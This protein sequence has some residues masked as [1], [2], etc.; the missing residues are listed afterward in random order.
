MY[1]YVHVIPQHYGHSIVLD[2]EDMYMYIY[3]TF[4]LRCALNCPQV[5][6]YSTPVHPTGHPSQ[7]YCHARNN[8]KIRQQ[9]D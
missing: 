9:C 5:I 8:V 3:K 7:I 4:Y 2:C 6:V 1:P